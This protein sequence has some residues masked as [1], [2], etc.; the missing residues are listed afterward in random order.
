MSN[1]DKPDDETPELDETTLD[2]ESKHMLEYLKSGDLEDSMEH[3]EKMGIAAL[4]KILYSVSA[5]ITFINGFCTVGKLD[6]AE[7]YFKDMVKRGFVPD[8]TTYDV[9]VGAFLET[10]KFEEATK[11]FND[12]AAKG[13]ST[14][15]FYTVYINFFAK[16]N[17]IE[18]ALHYFKEKEK[19][20]TPPTSADYSTIVDAYVRSGK[21]G[22]AIQLAKTMVQKKIQP[23]AQ[24]CNS[25]VVWLVKTNQLTDAQH[26]LNLLSNDN[27]QV[28]PKVQVA[29]A[30][31]IGAYINLGL[32]NSALDCFG[33]FVNLGIR[34]QIATVN[35]LFEGLLK[36]GDDRSVIQQWMSSL[37]ELETPPNI[38]TYN[39]LIGGYLANG[40]INEAKYW[41]AQLE[42]T[43]L[44]PNQ[45]T[46]DLKTQLKKLEK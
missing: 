30:A 29:H 44:E 14:R 17:Q 20:E 2:D 15:D 34:P 43:K 40:K 11:Y 32:V 19:T 21:P 45:K 1:K 4:D 37:T 33:N 26:W 3:A 39:I 25:L 8:E 27:G 36:R 10:G 41:L 6:I 12:M 38:D 16:T 7:D 13:D 22:L 46:L 31:L 35:L 28:D 18:K 24:F 5:Y 23:D 9:L 42:N